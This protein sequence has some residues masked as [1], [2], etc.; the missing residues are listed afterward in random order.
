[1]LKG[2]RTK[3]K[4]D[5]LCHWINMEFPISIGLWNPIMIKEVK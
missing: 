1:M 3:A 4:S 2:L 5:V